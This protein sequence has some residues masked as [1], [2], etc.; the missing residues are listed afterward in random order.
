MSADTFTVQ[1]I[2][3]YLVATAQ[4]MVARQIAQASDPSLV[5]GSQALL[6]K[7]SSIVSAQS[8]EL[9]QRGMPGREEHERPEQE[10][11]GDRDHGDD[12]GEPPRLAQAALDPGAPP[13]LV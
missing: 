12:G 2:R 13:A 4:E 3:N 1:I 9:V 8:P 6:D 5:Q 7:M 11:D 10:G